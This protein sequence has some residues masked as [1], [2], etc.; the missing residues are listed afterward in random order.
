M[1]FL[2][3]SVYLVGNEISAILDYTQESGCNPDAALRTRW[4]R[5][6][7]I[8]ML[9][10]A[11]VFIAGLFAWTLLE[12]VIHGVL[13]HAHRTFVSGLHEVHHRDPRAGFAL[14]A[15]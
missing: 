14:G 2:P 11:L 5:L 9:T 3:S 8:I 13:G 7:I 4:A 6:T 15:S 10:D 1:I 12:Y